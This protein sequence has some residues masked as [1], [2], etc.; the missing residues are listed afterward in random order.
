MEFRE[1]AGIFQE[2]EKTSLR[3]EKM[4]ILAKLIGKMEGEEL[5]QAIYLA[6]GRLGPLYD[7]LELNLAEKMA[8]R[9]VAWA[10][11]VVEKE[12]WERYKEVGDL[13]D[14]IVFLRDD[15]FTVHRSP[16]TVEEVYEELVGIAK[17]SGQGS[18]ERKI[19]RLGKLLQNLDSLSA[20]Y[21]VRLVVGRLRLG[22]SDMTVLDGLSFYLV[23]DKSLSKELE[24][25]YQIAPDIGELAK[26]VREGGVEKARKEMKLEVGRPIMPALAQRLRTAEE[27]IEKMGRV[28]AEPKF[29][30]QRC[31]VGSTGVLVKGRGY[32]TVRELRVGDEVL[33][34]KGNFRRVIAIAKRSRRKGERI[35]ELT[36]MMGDKLR[37]SEDHQVLVVNR[38]GWVRWLPVSMIGDE[39]LFYPQ[40]SLSQYPEVE[41]V[42]ALVDEAGYRKEV[43]M[44]KAV[45]RF[46]GFWVGDGLSN[47]YHGNERVGI[48]CNAKH[49]KLIKEYEEII[50]RELQ[51]KKL[52]YD[53]RNGAIV[54][55][56]RDR[57]MLKWLRSEFRGPGGRGKK[58][59]HWMLGIDKARWEAFLQGW[60]EADGTKRHGGGFKIVTKERQMAMMGQLLCAKHGKLVGIR[61]VRMPISQERK[62]TYYELIVPGTERYWRKMEG[63]YKVKKLYLKELK[64]NINHRIKLYDIQVEEDESFCVSV[65][66]LHNCQIHYSVD[67]IGEK[68]QSQNGLFKEEEKGGWAKSFTRSLEENT[69]MFPE[70]EQAK[71]QIKAKSV[72]LDSEAVGFDPKTGKMVPF[73]VTIKRKRKYGV[74]KLSRELPLKFFVF[75][76]MYKDGKSL[77]DLPLVERRRLLAETIR[78]GEVLVVDEGIIT[79]DAEELRQYHRQ[80]LAEGLEGVMVKKAEGKYHP[81]RKGWNW[82]KFKEEEGKTG[83]LVDTLDCVV[84]GYYQGRGKRNKFGL[85]AFLVGVRQGNKYV[86]VAK[87]GTGLTDEEWR[88]MN[89]RLRRVTSDG[90]PG[91]YEVAK[92][93]EPDGW[94]YPQVVVEV[95]ADEIT[96]SPVHTSGYALRFPRLVRFRDDKK[97]EEVTSLKE[98]KEIGGVG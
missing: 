5:K 62:K 87:I 55:Y 93:L 1:L 21:V 63:G 29:D 15:K 11:G 27:M 44:N 68:R 73:Q 42:K 83:K 77:L 66:S 79:E 43:K 56:W 70:L 92:E 80:K 26:V 32:I 61:R 53:W 8:V 95:A 18:Q 50:R 22:F 12:V 7:S 84:M 46:L 65:A 3:N 20:K 85:G 25:I 86:T 40:P 96:K 58:I 36:S 81:G 51:I 13:G 10:T 41:K 39:W 59:P 28:V 91:E 6:L 69:R 2:I 60:R 90:R 45:M 24:E 4:E 76:I 52:S 19:R 34:H 37:L 54:I 82:V 75:D 74:G 88:E 33:T 30:G 57:M 89:R 31:V 16:F 98:V 67:E 94:V 64:K 71:E 47:D 35:F 23:G 78:K 38:D 9:V 97:P 14:V 48:V 72:I 49:K 17:E